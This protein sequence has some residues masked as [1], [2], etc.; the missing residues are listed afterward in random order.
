[1]DTSAKLTVSQLTDL[2]RH[3]LESGFPHVLVEGE[4]SNFRPSSAGHW[5]FTLKDANASIQ[6]VM[7]KNRTRSL[8]FQPKD[9]MLLK[10]R[11]SLS[12]YAQRGTYSIVVE[13]MERSGEGDILAMLEDRKR[14][15]AAEGLFNNDRKRPLPRFPQTVAVVTSPTGAA[16]RDII[17]VL[18][19]R[20]RGIRVIILPAPVQGIEAAPII[21]QRIRQANHWKIADVLIVGRGGGSLEDLL[22][23]SEEAVVRAVA[24][25]EIPVV[26]AVGHEI[27]WSLADYAADLRAPTPSAAAE[28][29]SENREE[30][31]YKVR[32]T[33]DDFLSIMLNRIERAR[34]LARP[35]SS[36][37][38]EYRFRNILQP[39]FLRFDDAKD[40]LVKNMGKRTMELKRRLDLAKTSLEASS[41]LAILERGFSVVNILRNG[42]ADS[43]VRSA[44]DV[45]LGDHLSIRPLKGTITA[46]VEN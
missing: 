1:M 31:L 5:Y 22:P 46:V 2:I 33:A 9:G 14:K 34:L 30:A 13:E 36:D 3:T 23:F 43:I 27:D 10:A 39:Y 37:D 15:L 16:L 38:L 19:R 35:F 24:A 4:L 26:S 17:N 6:A 25:S 41:P 42:K 32:S 8:A 28:L 40:L 44:S 20:A 12:V 7:F 11:G 45:K 18:K 29:V 21:A